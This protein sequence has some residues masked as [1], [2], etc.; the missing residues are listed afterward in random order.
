MGRSVAVAHAGSADTASD[1]IDNIVIVTIAIAF[2][3][4]VAYTGV[5]RCGCIAYSQPVAFGFFIRGRYSVHSCSY[6]F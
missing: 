5:S 1:A 2:I 4:V 6:A 3:I